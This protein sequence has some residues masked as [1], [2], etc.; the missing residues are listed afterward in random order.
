MGKKK[1]IKLIT[2]FLVNGNITKKDADKLLFELLNKEH[3]EVNETNHKRVKTPS[4]PKIDQDKVIK[5]K[6][7]M[8]NE[9]TGKFH[10]GF[11][12]EI[13]KKPMSRIIRE[14]CTEICGVCGSTKSRNGLFGWFGQY[15]CHNMKCSTNT[16]KGGIGTN[17]ID[18]D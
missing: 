16:I 13:P 4:A 5:S 1:S 15:R 9:A 10:E 11:K 2:K 3:K 17:I 8:F 12:L 18:V 14:G 6:P 7:V